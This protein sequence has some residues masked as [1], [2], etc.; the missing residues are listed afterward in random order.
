MYVH[1]SVAKKKYLYSIS[2]KF[3]TAVKQFLS[4][5]YG[6]CSGSQNGTALIMC[7]QVHHNQSSRLVFLAVFSLVRICQ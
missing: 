3:A 1:H 6:I 7:M 5:F 4:C 2:M